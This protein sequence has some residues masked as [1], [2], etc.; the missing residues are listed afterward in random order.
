MNHLGDD[1]HLAAQTAYDKLRIKRLNV[2]RSPCYGFSTRL[3]Q[4]IENTTLGAPPLSR[5]RIAWLAKITGAAHPTVKC[6]LKE[7]TVPSF[8]VLDLVARFLLAHQKFVESSP[9]LIM[10]WLTFGDKS[11]NPYKSPEESIGPSNTQG[12][13]EKRSLVPLANALIAEFMIKKK[14]TRADFDYPRVLNETVGM[15]EHAD[16]ESMSQVKPAHRDIIIGAIKLYAK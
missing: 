3:N 16:I 13:E 2:L 15:L 11:L 6:W 14:L 7:D 10:S 8:D 12:H 9:E 1:P 4:L 5:G